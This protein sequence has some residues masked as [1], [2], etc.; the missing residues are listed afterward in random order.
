[1]LGTRVDLGRITVLTFVTRAINDHR[2][3]RI[4]TKLLSGPST[5]V[6]SS[7]GHIA[8]LVNPPGNPRAAYYIGGE[9]GPDPEQWRETAEQRSGTWWE[10]WDDWVLE[11]SGDERRRRR[12]PAC[13]P[14]VARAGGGVL[15]RGPGGALAHHD[16]AGL[17]VDVT[18]PSRLATATI[19]RVNR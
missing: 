2:T 17:Q 12:R 3:P 7:G 19:R 11:R 4:G 8:S 10:A 1:M 15:R 18:R 13:R 16:P 5:F 14:P 6:L 9:P